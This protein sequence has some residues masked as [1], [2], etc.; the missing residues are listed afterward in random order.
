MA[1][2]ELKQFVVNI[3]T[4]AQIEAG[5]SGGTITSDML[6]IS[7]DAPEYATQTWVGQQGFLTS[8]ALTG[9]ATETWVGNQG[10]I[11]GITS[12]DVTTALGYTPYSSSNPNGYTSNVGT[13]TSVNNTS[14]DGNG[15]VSLTIP[16]PLPSQTGQSGKYLTTDGTDASWAS[17]PSDSS[18]ADVDLSNINPT[19]SAKAT[20]VGWGIPDYTSGI[21]LS[22]SSFP[23]TAPSDGFIYQA[24]SNCKMS[25]NDNEAIYNGTAGGDGA[26]IAKNDVVKIT[27]GSFAR[28]YFY[29]LKGV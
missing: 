25:V 21:A 3:G 17:I 1:D 16:A 26:V 28:C 12:S 19:A 24:A 2:T 18:K 7:T 11:T 4:T 14:P 5:I 10:Y 27:E 20:I 23:Y 15:N 9:Y 22:S 8:S 13:V 29:P 6:S